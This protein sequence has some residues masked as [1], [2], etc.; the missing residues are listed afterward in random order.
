[1]ATVELLLLRHGIAQDR[2]L[3]AAQGVPERDRSLT[4]E[5]RARTAAV[6]ERLV[7]LGFRCDWLLTS[8]LPRAFQT[9]ELALA[10]G[11]APRM[12]LAPELEPDADP[13]ALLR[14]WLG[15]DP[16]VPGWRRLCLVGHEPDLSKLAAV[17]CGAPAW[18][19]RLKK[20]GVAVLELPSPGQEPAAASAGACLTHL[21]T[22][23]SLSAPLRR[24]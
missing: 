1:M 19:L 20:A 13:L 18:A 12:G 14:R 23:R 16:P 21:L 10:A 24:T 5:G 15:P 22:P 4:R 17:L 2:A 9:A 8:S 11:L 3:A 7:S 6:A